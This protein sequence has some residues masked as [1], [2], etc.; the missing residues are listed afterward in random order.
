MPGHKAGRVPSED[1]V[2][3]ILAVRGRKVMLDSD[4]AELYGVEVKR[5]NEQVSR[6]QDR[7]PEEF[8]F[9]MSS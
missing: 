7:F 9:R 6:N 8:A 4:L 2:A 3:R 5:L 1:I